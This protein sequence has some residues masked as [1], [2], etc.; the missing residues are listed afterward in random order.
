M[1]LG[2]LVEDD[3]MFFDYWGEKK[4]LW[5]MFLLLVASI[6][7]FCVKLGQFVQT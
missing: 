5:Q 4:D 3:E 7:T 6:A 2:C 1:V